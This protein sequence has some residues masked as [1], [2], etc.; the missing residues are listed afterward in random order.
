MVAPRR[1]KRENVSFPV[2][3]RRSKTPLLKLPN[4]AHEFSSSVKCVLERFHIEKFRETQLEA[5]INLL[6]GKDILVLQPTGSGKSLIFQSCPLIV[7]E[8][9]SQSFLVVLWS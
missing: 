5:I 2:A 4:S 6:Q 3:V 9:R 7:D 8:L 1:V